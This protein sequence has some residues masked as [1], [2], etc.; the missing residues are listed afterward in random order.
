MFP[1]F[2][3]FIFRWIP[4]SIRR[5]LWCGVQHDEN[6]EISLENK[7]K[8]SSSPYSIANESTYKSFTDFNSLDPDIPYTSSVAEDNDEPITESAQHKTKLPNDFGT[9]LAPNS[10]DNSGLDNS[11][12]TVDE[13]NATNI[14]STKL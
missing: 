13:Y 1:I 12:Y 10:V 4:S 6:S 9:V 8:K 5:K 7:D 11:S 3:H 14:L 2:D